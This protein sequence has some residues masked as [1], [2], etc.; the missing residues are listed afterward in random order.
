MEPGAAGHGND[1]HGRYLL[2]TSYEHPHD[3]RWGIDVL[4]ET[5]PDAFDHARPDGSHELRRN[6]VPV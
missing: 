3:G 1:P 4:E 6:R 5:S 2:Y